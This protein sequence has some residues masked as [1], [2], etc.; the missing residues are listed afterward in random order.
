MYETL[1]AAPL[2]EEGELGLVLND[3]DGRKTDEILKTLSDTTWNDDDDLDG[4]R[5]KRDRLR[6]LLEL[7]AVALKRRDAISELVPS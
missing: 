7:P 1:A 3:E 4:L 6:I 2:L 5:K